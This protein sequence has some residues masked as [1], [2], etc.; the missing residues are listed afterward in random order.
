MT[1]TREQVKQ[2]A[3]EHPTASMAEIARHL[4]VS[5]ERVRQIVDEEGLTVGHDVLCADDK[6]RPATVGTRTL[7]R[8]R[9]ITGGLP[10]AL[11]ATAV[12]TAS[13]LL[14]AADLTARGWAVF[15]PL[16]RTACCDLV[17]VG[18]DGAVERVEVRSAKR[19]AAGLLQFSSPDRS[20][21]D[22]R[23]LVVTG[24]PVTYRPPFPNETNRR[25][26]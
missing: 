8:A 9:V 25:R 19:S 3:H 4:G 11:N 14:T 10:V 23:A 5:R 12:G 21:S 20:K 24:E 15:F 7:P 16:V 26:R 2:L 6:W 13:E 18:K 17:I 1:D 22:R